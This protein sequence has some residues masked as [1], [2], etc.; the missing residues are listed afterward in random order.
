LLVA[1]HVAAAVEPWPVAY[2]VAAEPVEP[3]LVVHAFVAVNV[4]A[5]FE[6]VCVVGQIAV[7]PVHAELAVHVVLAWQQLGVVLVWLH[8]YHEPVV[9]HVARNLKLLVVSLH[10]YVD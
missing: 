9:A 10:L 5:R 6:P 1:V 3:L 7:L 2:V 8:L 4:V